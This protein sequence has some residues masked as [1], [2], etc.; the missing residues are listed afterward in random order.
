[1]QLHFHIILL[2]RIYNQICMIS[3]KKNIPSE[4]H[5]NSCSRERRKYPPLLTT[6]HSSSRTDN[7]LSRLHSRTVITRSTGKQIDDNVFLSEESS[8]RPLETASSMSSRVAANNSMYLLPR[9]ILSLDM[10][11]FE[12]SL[13]ANST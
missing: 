12:S 2:L 1:M 3:I 8:Y 9:V 6:T 7:H 13:F 4:K 5:T 10:A 11:A